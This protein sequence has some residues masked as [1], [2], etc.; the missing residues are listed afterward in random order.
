MGGCSVTAELV[1]WIHKSIFIP[2]LV[3]FVAVDQYSNNYDNDN[4]G[5][6]RYNDGDYCDW[7]VSHIAWNKHINLVLICCSNLTTCFM[8]ETTLVIHLY[9]VAIQIRISTWSESTVCTSSLPLSCKYHFHRA[10]RLQS[11]RYPTYSMS[12]LLLHS[13]ALP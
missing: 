7:I 13:D 3:D 6:T 11:A 1:C 5:Q 4:D 10:T 2:V 12:A 8:S 9:S